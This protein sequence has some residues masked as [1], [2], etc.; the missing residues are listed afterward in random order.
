MGG[1][2]GSGQSQSKST[3]TSVNTTTLTEIGDIGLTGRDF[4][5]VVRVLDSGAGVSGGR[6]ID[7]SANAGGRILDATGQTG[8]AILN[9]TG[10]S[11][12]NILTATLYA[13]AQILGFGSQ[14]ADAGGNAI[15]AQAGQSSRDI[16]GAS[17]RVT[18]TLVHGGA[19]V[20]RAMID[21]GTTFS[22]N[23]FDATISGANMVDRAGERVYLT[24]TA[25]LDS[26]ENVAHTILSSVGENAMAQVIANSGAVDKLK[27]PD[28]SSDKG[29]NQTMI[30]LTVA[31]LFV[32]VMLAR[33]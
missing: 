16:L 14:T 27:A 29:F 33:K 3:S 11:G 32:T 22:G 5:E 30:L 8:G 23:L 28:T 15:L 13:L 1:G 26:V 4:V 18:N 17:A 2:G 20:G 7:A 19:D 25:L 9:A 24:G 21:A 12:A 31:G 10:Q 6:I